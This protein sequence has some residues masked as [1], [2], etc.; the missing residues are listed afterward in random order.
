MRRHPAG[1]LMLGIALEEFV[2]R[3]EHCELAGPVVDGPL[4]GVGTTS[5]PLRVRGV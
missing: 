5:V 4:G 2:L 1:R 3:T